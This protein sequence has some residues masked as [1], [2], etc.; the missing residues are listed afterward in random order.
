[1]R[2]KLRAA[3][4]GPNYNPYA[5]HTRNDEWRAV[6]S[7]ES[8]LSYGGRDRSSGPSAFTWTEGRRRPAA[9]GS[10]ATDCELGNAG[11]K[12]TLMPNLP[13]RLA[14]RVEGDRW[15]AYVA[16][17]D[18]MDGAIWVGSI[19]MATVVDNPARK[20]AF[21]C[22]MQETM[23]DVIEQTVGTRPDWPNPPERAPEHER[24]GSA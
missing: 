12:E 2:P 11:L 22:L 19:L 18:T 8:V 14:L 17:Q 1:M 3:V 24:S 21:M 20:A 13:V 10:P 15:S 4:F 5:Q 6:Q 16:Q 9:G 23:S 7:A